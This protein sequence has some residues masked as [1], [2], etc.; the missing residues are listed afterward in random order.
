MCG[1]E[2][3]LQNFRIDDCL[4]PSG[5]MFGVLLSRD[6]AG[7]SAGCRSCLH[8]E[9]Y[10]VSLFPRQELLGRLW[11]RGRPRR[12][13]R[14]R[15]GLL[16]LRGCRPGRSRYGLRRA[17]HRLPIGCHRRDVA[18]G[19]VNLF[20]GLSSLRPLLGVFEESDNGNYKCIDYNFFHCSVFCKF[21]TK[22]L[23]IEFFAKEFML[24]LW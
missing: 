13:L 4:T 19:C 5:V 23:N 2:F 17:K 15:R 12:F 18:F 16:M 11:R 22:L 1:L 9:T 21:A 8:R 3:P 20:A 14:G 10:F 6:A 7:Q 24:K